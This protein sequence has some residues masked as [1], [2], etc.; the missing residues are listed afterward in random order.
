MPTTAA[1]SD[2][3]FLRVWACNSTVFINH[4]I[5][6]MYQRYVAVNNTNGGHTRCLLSFLISSQTCDALLTKVSEKNILETSYA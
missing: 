5:L 3:S 6:S 2:T 4:C 1:E